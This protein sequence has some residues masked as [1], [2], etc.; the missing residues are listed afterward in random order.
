MATADGAVWCLATADGEPRWR[1]QAGGQARL[2]LTRETHNAPASRS[3]HRRGMTDCERFGGIPCAAHRKIDIE[4][5]ERGIVHPAPYG[6]V[7]AP[8]HVWLAPDGRVLLS[9]PYFIEK[10]EMIWC[11][12][13]A[14]Q[15][16]DAGPDADLDQVPMGEMPEGAAPPM[17]LIVGGSYDPRGEILK[18]KRSPRRPTGLSTGPAVPSRADT[19]TLLSELTSGERELDPA[20]L[21]KLALTSEPEALSYVEKRLTK[22]S[23]REGSAFR[24][25]AVRSI[26]SVGASA[27]WTV[28][29]KLARDREDEIRNEVAVAFEQLAAPESAETVATSLKRE[30]RPEVKK[31]WIR[32]LGSVAGADEDART[33]LLKYA[34]SSRDAVLRA[35]ALI[36][37]ASLAPDDSIRDALVE[38]LEDAEPLVRQAA[39]CALVRATV[40]D[41]VAD[42]DEAIATEKDAEGRDL[43]LRARAALAKDAAT[44]KAPKWLADAI[45]RVAGDEIPR[46]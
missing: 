22:R 46:R 30:K 36:A 31:N 26:G 3:E 2:A 19:L 25:R 34:R 16:L 37:M 9:V 15:L 33:T 1:Y 42:L 35:N 13:R 24:A 39:A 11:F 40:T 4:M 7:I 43:L 14:R 44:G 29:A 6:R 18:P 38:G 12:L 5:R 20:S 8:Q 45:S 32:A 23:G 27:W 17:R 28:L 41:A 21:E 10:N